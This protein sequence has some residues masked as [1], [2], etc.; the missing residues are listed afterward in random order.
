MNDIEVRMRVFEAVYSTASM[1]LR[2]SPDKIIN[3]CLQ[4]EKYVLGLN[5]TGPTRKKDKV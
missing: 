3:N 4:Y 5:T 1:E 2:T